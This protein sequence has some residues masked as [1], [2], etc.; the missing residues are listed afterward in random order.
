MLFDEIREEQNKQARDALKELREQELLLNNTAKEIRELGFN[1][2]KT[3]FVETLQGDDSEV[4]EIIN[5][6][7][8][9]NSYIANRI[10]LQ[11]WKRL[12]RKKFA[13]KETCKEVKN[14]LENKIDQLGSQLVK[15]KKWLV[16]TFFL[17]FI[18]W[19][20]SCRTSRCFYWNSYWNICSRGCSFC[21]VPIFK[22]CEFP[23]NVDGGHRC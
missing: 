23:H 11:N 4:A 22:S 13:L 9:F 2:S 1:L 14:K 6:N 19:S 7:T 12:Q 3:F 5:S 21:F 8:I 20:I 10:L 16:I 17:V 18:F 15:E